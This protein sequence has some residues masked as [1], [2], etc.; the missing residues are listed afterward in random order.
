M[1]FVIW[2]VEVTKKNKGKVIIWELTEQWDVQSFSEG[3]YCPEA[4]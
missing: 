2:E 4:Q 3:S 1:Q